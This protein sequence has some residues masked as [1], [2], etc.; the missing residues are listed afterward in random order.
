M[1]QMTSNQDGSHPQFTY[2]QHAETGPDGEFTMT[3][4]YSTT[5]YENFGPEEN[6][7]T[8]VSV[9]AADAYEFTTGNQTLDDGLTVVEYADSADV[10]EA[11]VL[12]E[13][14]EPVTVDLER[15]VV[16]EPE[17]ANNSTTE[18]LT[19]DVDLTAS[20]MTGDDSDGDS[21]TGGVDLTTGA[22]PALVG[23]A[24]LGRLR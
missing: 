3:L 1:S 15:E 2:R 5:G 19:P 22:V 6:G 18:S 10:S 12:G 17:G 24:A 11:Q 7:H 4:P 23:A 14:D 16:H 13:G 8:N 9:R 20:E 21:G